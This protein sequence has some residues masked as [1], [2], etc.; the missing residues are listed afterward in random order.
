MITPGGRV[1][2]STPLGHKGGRRQL[3]DYVRAV[4]HALMRKHGWDESH[5]IAVAKNSLKRWRRGGG[6]VR[7]QVRAGAAAHLGIQEGLD[8][9]RGGGTHNLSVVA[10][11]QDGGRVTMSPVTTATR[12]KRRA[13]SIPA[14]RGKGAFPI[15]S[16]KS[17]RSAASLLSK[18]NL[19][20][21]VVV[22]HVRAEA[23]KRGLKLTPAFKASLS[24]TVD[25][26][27]KPYRFRHGWIPITPGGEAA[28]AAFEKRTGFKGKTRVQGVQLPSTSRTKGKTP[29]RAPA[30]AYTPER[31]AAAVAALRAEHDRRQAAK[32]AEATGRIGAAR[33]Q[34]LA[35]RRTIPELAR[36]VGST[37]PGSVEHKAAK[38]EIARRA[39][40]TPDDPRIQTAS[41]K[42]A[43]RAGLNDNPARAALRERVL[44]EQ[45]RSA[46]LQP[47]A[48]KGARF[49]VR[50]AEL[51][52][53]HVV[54]D[55]HNE[56]AVVGNHGGRSVSFRGKPNAAKRANDLNKLH[57]EHLARTDG[58]RGVQVFGNDGQALLSNRGH[59]VSGSAGR[60]MADPNAR[61]RVHEVN[62]RHV[63][64]DH[65]TPGPAPGGG[66]HVRT[67]LGKPNAA[68]HANDLNANKP[69]GKFDRRGAA[70]R[71]DENARIRAHAQSPASRGT[72][73]LQAF[74][75]GSKPMPSTMT[76]EAVVAE[77]HKRGGGTVKP[78]AKPDRIPV[79]IRKDDSGDH[80]VDHGATGLMTDEGSPRWSIN[81]HATDPKATHEAWIK[82][83]AT[84]DRLAALAPHLNRLL[85]TH[86]VET[87]RNPNADSIRL[88]TTDLPDGSV[89]VS[90]YDSGRG[91]GFIDPKG[92]TLTDTSH[93]RHSYTG[94]WSKS[95]SNNRL[96]KAEKDN[97]AHAAAT[98]RAPSPTGNLTLNRAQANQK[99]QEERR[100]AIAAREARSREATKSRATEDLRGAS[101]QMVQ[102]STTHPKL[103]VRQ[104]AQAELSRRATAKQQDAAA[105]QRVLDTQSTASLRNIARGE[106]D[107]S[108]AQRAAARAIL[109]QRVAKQGQ[110]NREMNRRQGGPT[111]HGR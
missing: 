104:A 15:T 48:S 19:P 50:E 28:K 85:Q 37:P 1:G 29:S 44:A 81:A 111:P 88:A 54:V 14:G 21:S 80:V 110:Q 10:S 97:A 89:H 102:A 107:Y 42:A 90:N 30:G 41:D 46:E 34:D 99:A 76:R 60:K 55:T 100:A 71:V 101:D 84:A 31:G 26:A 49:Q 58:A 108:P 92:N 64:V 43:A 87:K 73:D 25:L 94:E 45:G 40:T 61:F 83:R 66:T 96:T 82:D 91:I 74:A 27:H 17:V 16:Q 109:I 65:Q 4:A 53:H 23:K 57:S 12:K 9:S 7:P 6:K 22:A 78:A 93:R 98:Q 67:F 72:E 68:K 69:T 24:T 103:E 63:V 36:V 59:T 105:I 51:S 18:T 20:R 33:P 62:G 86:G 56:D 5:A 35:Q 32:Q 75:D 52:N 77:L 39:G 8:K 95:L 47:P 70:D 11:A 79:A 106:G 38:A 13:G 3:D 2:D